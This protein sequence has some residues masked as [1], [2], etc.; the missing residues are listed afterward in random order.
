MF[1]FRFYGLCVFDT[2]RAGQCHIYASW[3][4]NVFVFTCEHLTRVNNTI[5]H[6]ILFREYYMNR[7]DRKLSNGQL[8]HMFFISSIATNSPTQC[9]AEQIDKFSF[10]PSINLNRKKNAGSNCLVHQITKFTHTNQM[11]SHEIVVCAFG[12]EPHSAVNSGEFRH[13]ECRSGLL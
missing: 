5:N 4:L 2:S 8:W 10:I 1:H 6:I 13:T 7:W 12:V 3:K 11:A 9:N